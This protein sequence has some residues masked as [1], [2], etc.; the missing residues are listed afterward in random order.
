MA[1]RT[2]DSEV[3]AVIQMRATV[4]TTPFITAA[5][6]L[7]DWIETCDDADANVLT[8]SQLLTLETFLAAHFVA[9]RDEQWS[10]TSNAGRSGSRQGQT[11]LHFNSTFWGQTALQ[12]D[13]SGCLAKRQAEILAGGRAKATFLWLGT[14]DVPNATD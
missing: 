4:S 11:Q 8:S 14:E 5:S 7:V 2:N 12:L 3:R 10:S 9:V 13:V 1:I 6:A